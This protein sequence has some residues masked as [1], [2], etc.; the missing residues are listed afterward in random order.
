MNTRLTISNL[1]I[2]EAVAHPERVERSLP[3]RTHQAAT[4]AF[5]RD[6]LKQESGC[7]FVARY[8]KDMLRPLR[9]LL[10][11]LGWWHVSLQTKI[12]EAP[13]LLAR[14]RLVKQALSK[15][16]VEQ[17]KLPITQ[18]EIDK[19]QDQMALEKDTLCKTELL[20]DLALV[21]TFG[22][23]ETD[24]RSVC[25]VFKLC[26]LPTEQEKRD[27]KATLAW[28]FRLSAHVDIL[29]KSL[30]FMSKT[31]KSHLQELIAVHKSCLAAEAY[32][33][34]VV[35]VQGFTKVSRDMMCTTH[36]SQ[37]IQD[38]QHERQNLVAL[39]FPEEVLGT[40]ESFRDIPTHIEQHILQ[41]IGVIYKDTCDALI[42][43][44]KE[45]FCFYRQGRMTQ[46]R[47]ERVVDHLLTRCE[48]TQ[49]QVVWQETL[50][51]IQKLYMGLKSKSGAGSPEIQALRQQLNEMRQGLIQQIKEQQ[52]LQ[53]LQIEHCLDR[54]QLEG[55]YY[56][57][58][59]NLLSEDL[60][61]QV[62]AISGCVRAHLRYKV[63]LDQDT[64]VTQETIRSA[65]TQKQEK[66]EAE[67]VRIE[68]ELSGVNET[69]RAWEEKTLRLTEEK[70]CLM[71]NEP[72]SLKETKTPVQASAWSQ[73]VKWPDKRSASSKSSSPS[74]SVSL[75]EQLRQI[76]RDLDVN[77]ETLTHLLGE[78]QNLESKLLELTR[79][80]FDDMDIFEYNL[81]KCMRALTLKALHQGRG[82]LDGIG[83]VL[84][85]KLKSFKIEPQWRKFLIEQFV[86]TEV[87][88]HI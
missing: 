69:I 81:K 14:L 7:V 56:L 13:D 85:E 2:Y 27:G 67:R 9:N 38:Y 40:L 77:A 76:Q 68:Q 44:L 8:F 41:Q 66:V 46:A 53:L 42:D 30:P 58:Y 80:V 43:N 61:T 26:L 59:F 20:I 29:Q 49:E 12:Q 84:E 3:L 32:G 63:R 45:C 52:G 25:E 48:A 15:N 65:M 11:R 87:R 74:L 72:V 51:I 10:E 17:I 86:Q 54:Q 21:E 34:S 57:S 60:E 62:R 55:V 35:R 73:L 78:K 64:P 22:D 23:I 50:F 6:S 88:A 79:V 5:L 70:R 37:D 19:L 16:P 33:Q 4:G 18:Q 39:G 31:I 1:P 83:P 82:Q 75:E 28:T 24:Y 36:T 47:W 71:A